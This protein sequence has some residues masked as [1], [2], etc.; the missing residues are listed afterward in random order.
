MGRPSTSPPTHSAGSTPVVLLVDDHADNRDL[1]A[2]FLRFEGFEAH[3]ATDGRDA[4]E[5]ARIVTPDCIV[6]DLSLPVMDGWTAIRR[7]RA[8]E[9]T[10]AIPIIALT[11]HAL[12]GQER[13]ARESGCD[14][15]LTKPCLP[16]ELAAEIRRLLQGSVRR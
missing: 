1:Y 3:T 8:N 7:L 11:G 16:D 12:T 9:K 13:I 15:F 14:R 4:I 5:Q 10:R 2:M 6:M